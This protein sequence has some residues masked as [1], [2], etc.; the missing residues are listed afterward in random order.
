MFRDQIYIQI[1]SLYLFFPKYQV[2]SYKKV[3]D[4]VTH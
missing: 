2:I 4:N 1:E 3:K